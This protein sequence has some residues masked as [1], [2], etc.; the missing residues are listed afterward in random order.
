[1]EHALTIMAVYREYASYLNKVDNHI[2]LC[3]ITYLLGS[4]IPNSPLVPQF[5]EILGHFY[6]QYTSL[7]SYVLHLNDKYICKRRNVDYIL[8]SV[9]QYGGP[10][11]PHTP[12][13]GGFDN[14][15]DQHRIKG[16]I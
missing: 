5:V 13:F 10:E 1:M 2:K 16:Y 3:Y 12:L 14:T 7:Y 6:G 11:S 4:F 8:V 9:D 15:Q